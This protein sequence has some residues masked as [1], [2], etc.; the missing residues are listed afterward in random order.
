[1]NSKGLVAV[2]VL[3]LLPSAAH[4]SDG[5][6]AFLQYLFIFLLII[7]AVCSAL[8][9]QLVNE[10]NKSRE[11][12]KSALLA[13]VIAFLSTI[14]GAWLFLYAVFWISSKT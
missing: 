12:K 13:A 11:N 1:M 9:A 7:A 14:F 8:A 2:G 4:A 6:G 3:W 10:K 5:M